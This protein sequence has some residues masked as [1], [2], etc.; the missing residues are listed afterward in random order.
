[1]VEKSKKDGFCQDCQLKACEYYF[2]E[3]LWLLK[4]LFSVLVEDKKPT[5]ANYLGTIISNIGSSGLATLFLSQKG[6]CNESMVISRCFLERA[7]N[8]IYLLVCD[9]EEYKNFLDYSKQKVV[10]SFYAKQKAFKHV[11][12]EVPLPEDPLSFSFFSEELRKF[13][14]EKGGVKT[15]WTSLNLEERVEF[16]GRKVEGFNEKTGAVFKC[17]IAHIYEDASEAMHGTLY[18]GLFHMGVVYGKIEDSEVDAHTKGT[19]M[20]TLMLLGV[21]IHG[22]LEIV[23]K[24]KEI[25][26]LT[27]QSK[28]NR[29][30]ISKV[31]KK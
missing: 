27:E 9:E 20:T 22:I 6:L 14:G 7:I 31:F 26:E 23:S 3:Q 10:R 2:N 11:D 25:E 29:K 18:G 1:M 28:Q 5:R 24:E 13:T 15:R 12:V 30:V 21:L 19:T 4:K 16:V 17:A 8:F